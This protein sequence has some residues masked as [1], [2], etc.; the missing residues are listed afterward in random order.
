[1]NQ[2]VQFKENRPLFKDGTSREEIFASVPKAK[3]SEICKHLSKLFI[4]LASKENLDVDEKAI[5]MEVYAEKLKDYPNYA[6]EAAVTKFIDD[7]IFVPAISE[8]V[9]EVR[10]QVFKK[11]I[12]TDK[13][14]RDDPFD[15]VDKWAENK[16]ADF[17][18][19]TIK[20]VYGNQEDAP[21]GSTKPH[22][23]CTDNSG[24]EKREAMERLKSMAMKLDDEKAA[25]G[26]EFLGFENGGT[27]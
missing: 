5:R 3:F 25:K 27:Q 13:I 1:M 9:K 16:R 2:L 11:I 19:E 4:T 21:T 7:E 15:G 8:L 14:K 17:V 20:K 23:N 10:D 26:L 6:I 22:N 12:W 24:A 18:K